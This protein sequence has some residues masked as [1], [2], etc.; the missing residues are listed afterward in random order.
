M[1]KKYVIPESYNIYRK[2]PK[3]RTVK[4]F[5]QQAIGI[6]NLHRLT[7]DCVAIDNIVIDRKAIDNIVI[8]REAIDNIVI[9]REAIDCFAI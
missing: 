2:I 5:N 4:H 6:N 9:D 7:I 3:P 8:H 1:E